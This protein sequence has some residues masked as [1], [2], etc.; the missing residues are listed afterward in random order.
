MEKLISV[1]RAWLLEF[2]GMG[3]QRGGATE[4]RETQRR[5]TKSRR[6]DI[7]G[8][9]VA[10]AVHNVVVDDPNEKVHH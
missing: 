10:E 2:S 6:Q 7:H 1:K 5:R 4:G 3:Q 9:Q 8:E